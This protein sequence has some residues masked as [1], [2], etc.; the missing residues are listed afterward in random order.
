MGGKRSTWRRLTVIPFNATITGDSDIK[1]YTDYLYEHCGGAIL[2]W[3]IEGAKRFINAKFH[4]RIPN[5]VSAAVENYHSENDWVSAFLEECCEQ[6]DTYSAKAGDLYQFYRSY[7]ESI[8]EFKRSPQEFKT[9]ITSFGFTWH[10]FKTGAVYTGLRLK[11]S[12][13]EDDFLK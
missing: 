3:M 12:A 5:C 11:D 8:G 7:C 13:E 9:A 6:G 2:E 1:N 10:K 4:I